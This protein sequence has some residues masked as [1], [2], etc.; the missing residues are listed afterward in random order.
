MKAF[1]SNLLKS[2]KKFLNI[3]IIALQKAKNFAKNV[4]IKIHLVL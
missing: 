3:L 4:L 2:I 1:Y